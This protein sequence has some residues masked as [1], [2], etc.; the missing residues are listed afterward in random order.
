MK[1]RRLISDS[2]EIPHDIIIEV[3]KRLPVKSLLRFKCVCKI[4]NSTIS[5]PQFTETHRK[6]S[7]FRV[8]GN[9]LV[10]FWHYGD[11]IIVSFKNHD[12]RRSCTIPPPIHLKLKTPINSI[13]DRISI[14]PPMNGLVCLY[15]HKGRGHALVL[16]ITTRQILYL[17]K[18]ATKF[19]G[20]L[21]IG[22]DELTGEY[23][24]LNLY[25]ELGTLKCAIYTIGSDS[26]WR[27]TMDPPQTIHLVPGASRACVNGNMYWLVLDDWGVI[28]YLVAF[29]VGREVF[30]T[31]KFTES[32]T[33]RTRLLVL[34]GCL[35]CIPIHVYAERVEHP[36]EIWLLGEC[37]EDA[38]VLAKEKIR[39]P[40]KLSLKLALCEDSGVLPT[41]ELLLLDSNHSKKLYVDLKE[42]SI[43]EKRYQWSHPR[44]DEQD[45]FLSSLSYEIRY[46]HVENMYR[47]KYQDDVRYSRFLYLLRNVH[48]LEE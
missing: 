10:A 38:Q 47:F 44:K 4:W 21:E 22:F 32:L 40:K 13:R 8:G 9:Y 36:T 28:T 5:D 46:I 42:K 11:R 15:S 6:C 23:K 29:N 12:G 3:L 26:L 48:D 20:R 35:A 31:L 34:E 45:K 18:F 27:K 25:M 43:K 30:R 14:S 37:Q 7:R 39:F 16:N 33:C 41:T 24:V 19:V 2:I 17:P 1:K